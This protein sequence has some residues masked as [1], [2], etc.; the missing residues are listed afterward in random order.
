MKKLS[1]ILMLA[2]V[3]GSFAMAQTSNVSKK[4]TLMP[5][6]AVITDLKTGEVVRTTSGTIE[7]V[8]P[9]EPVQVTVNGTSSGPGTTGKVVNNNGLNTVQTLSSFGNT[10]SGP[11]STLKN[12]NVGALNSVQPVSGGLISTS[13]AVPPTNTNVVKP[14]V[15]SNQ[16][17]TVD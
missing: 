6:G 11:A 12:G 13:G 5:D 3:C 15:N 10:S 16:T 2:F 4:A 9:T 8:A 17:F 1:M 7:Y 14:P